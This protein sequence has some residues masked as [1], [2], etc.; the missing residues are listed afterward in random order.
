M[1]DGTENELDQLR[2]MVDHSFSQIEAQT[3]LININFSYPLFAAVLAGLMAAA[4]FITNNILYWLPAS[5]VVIYLWSVFS[6]KSWWTSRVNNAEAIR[7]ASK[8]INQE[9]FNFGLLW[10]LKNSSPLITAIG[11]LFLVNIVILLLVW[12]QIIKS[13]VPFDF[14]IPLIT[15]VIFIPIP[16]WLSSLINYVESGRLRIPVPKD[17]SLTDSPIKIAGILIFAI[18]YIFALLIMPFVSIKAMSFLFFHEGVSFWTAFGIMIIAMLVQVVCFILLSSY[19]SAVGAKKELSN[20]L[21][22]L[23][24]LSLQIDD[25]IL[26]DGKGPTSLD[27]LKDQYMKTRRF[28]LVTDDYMKIVPFYMLNMNREYLLHQK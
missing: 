26:N 2:D 12:V 10:L 7:D 4:G 1:D 13:V 24:A 8:S 18:I 14:W 16:I 27:M 19:F 23:S 22:I 6:G 15:S 5:F 21:T 20:T 9:Q 17:D 25:Y 28:N 3:K 11:L